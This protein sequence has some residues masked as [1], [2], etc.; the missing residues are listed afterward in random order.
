MRKIVIGLLSLITL[1]VISCSDDSPKRGL[2]PA[3]PAIIK[4]EPKTKSVIF[5]DLTSY[6]DSIDAIFKSE[7]FG[8]ILVRFGHTY[9][10]GLNEDEVDRI[11]KEF[12]LRNIWVVHRKSDTAPYELGWLPDAEELIFL[13][14]YDDGYNLLF[15]TIAYIPSKQLI[16]NGKKVKAAFN[17]EDYEECRRILQTE[18]KFKPIDAKGYERLK[19]AGLN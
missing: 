8:H 2:N 7:D 18:Y 17:K 19:E 6:Q 13:R 15:D 4:S 11:N 3:D 10:G 16:E 5:D 1:T 12:T 14:Q 9:S